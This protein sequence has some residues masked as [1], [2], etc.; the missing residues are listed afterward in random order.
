MVFEIIIAPGNHDIGYLDND[1]RRKIFSKEILKLDLYPLELYRA[2]FNFII[3]NLKIKDVTIRFDR[4]ISGKSK[5]NLSLLT[6]T[7]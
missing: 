1:L 2:G 4:R 5:M 6:F 3:D 7:A